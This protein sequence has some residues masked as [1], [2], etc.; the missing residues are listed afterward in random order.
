MIDGWITRPT[1]KAVAGAR[2]GLNFARVYRSKHTLVF[3][4]FPEG[5][6]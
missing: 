3:G 4:K 2:R 5:A 6:L 1:S